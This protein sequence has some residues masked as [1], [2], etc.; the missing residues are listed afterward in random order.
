MLLEAK[1]LYK[2]FGDK[3]VLNDLSLS[4]KE[5]TITCVIGPSGVGKTTLAY[6][7]AKSIKRNFV[8]ISVGGVSDEGEIVGHRKTYLGAGPGRIIDGLKRAKSSN[9]LFLIY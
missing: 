7:I 6:S 9:P 4:I 3:D 5:G 1:N 8:K 2:R